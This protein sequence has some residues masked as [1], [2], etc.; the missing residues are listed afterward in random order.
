MG[1]CGSRWSDFVPLWDYNITVSFY[2]ETESR[3]PFGFN[4]IVMR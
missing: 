4:P 2:G 1:D 3:F